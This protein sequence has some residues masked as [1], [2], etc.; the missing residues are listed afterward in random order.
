MGWLEE[1][2]RMESGQLWR[3][4][5]TGKRVGHEYE[6][7][8]RE[9]RQKREKKEGTMKILFG[10]K[11]KTKTKKNNNNNNKKKKMQK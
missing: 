2:G 5:V 7:G 6:R 1:K 4:E 10:N 8:R 9:A 11:T 3:R